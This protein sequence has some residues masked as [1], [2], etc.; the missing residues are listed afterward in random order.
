[1]NNE[2][3]FNDWIDSVGIDALAR[4]LKINTMTIKLWKIG[5][6]NPRIEQMRQIKK[7]TKGLITYEKIIDRKIPR[8]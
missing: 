8:G 1:M 6:T 4:K 7:F 3:S 5:R 2:V